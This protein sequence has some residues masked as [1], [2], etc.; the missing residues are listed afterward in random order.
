MF[1][2]KVVGKIK[3]RI[4]Y[5]VTYFVRNCAVNGVMYKNI[6]ALDRQQMAVWHMHVEC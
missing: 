6:A 4:L 3:T 5:S 1:H 2:T